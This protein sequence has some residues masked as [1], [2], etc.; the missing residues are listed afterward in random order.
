MRP[1]HAIPPQTKKGPLVHSFHQA[2]QLLP[3][4]YADL[5]DANE[6]KAQ[7]IGL[8]SLQIIRAFQQNNGLAVTNQVD[9][10][11]ARR[12]NE[13]LYEGNV[14]RRILGF[15]YDPKGKPKAGAKV[16][17]TYVKAGTTERIDETLTDETGAYLLYYDPKELTEPP[18][19]TLVVQVLDEKSQAILLSTPVENPKSS[20]T[21]DFHLNPTPNPSTPMLL[22]IH[23][24]ISR[25]NGLPAEGL[26]VLAFDQSLSTETPLGQAITTADGRYLIQYDASK[27]PTGKAKPDLLLKIMSPGKPDLVLA[28]S[29]VMYNAGK[30]ATI[31]VVVKEKDIPKTSEFERLLAAIMP[32][33]DGKPLSDLQENTT[34]QDFTYLARKTGWDARMIAMAVLAAKNAAETKLPAEYFYASSRAGLPTDAGALRRVSTQTVEEAWKK[35]AA[36]NIVPAHFGQETGVTLKAF[37]VHRG[38]RLLTTKARN[39]VSTLKEILDVS[40][41]GNAAL[42]EKFANLYFNHNGPPAAFWDKAKTEL[43]LSDNTIKALR[44]DGK[45]GFLTGNHAPLIQYLKKEGQLDSPAALISKGFYKKER[46]LE[47]LQGQNFAVPDSIEGKDAAE[48]R[49]RYAESMTR[50]MKISYPTAVLAEMVLAGEMPLSK[51]TQSGAQKSSKQ[52]KGSEGSDLR[53]QVHEFFSANNAFEIGK[54]PLKRY[55]EAKPDSTPTPE[56][57]AEI[58]RLQRTWQISPDDDTMRVLLEQDLD[59][60][61][62]I[63]Q[64]DEA[65]FVNRMGKQGI[66][67]A[68]ALLTWNQAHSVHSTVLQLTTAVG[69]YLAN[70]KPYVLSGATTV[71]TVPQ[72]TTKVGYP[73]LEQLFGDLDYC[74]CDHC[75][76]ILSPAAYLVDLLTFIDR[77]GEAERGGLKFSNPLDVLLTRRPDIEHLELSCKNTNTVLPYIDL[78]N[79]IL[80]YHV[81]KDTLSGFYG[82]NAGEMD[83]EELLATPEFV[84]DQVYDDAYDKLIDQVYPATLPF[85]EPLESLRLL[86]EQLE[87]PLPEAMEKLRKNDDFDPTGPDYGWNDILLEQLKISPEAFRVLTDSPWKTLPQYFGRFGMTYEAFDIDMC[88]AKTFARTLNIS[89]KE[90]T[91]LLRTTFIN[92]AAAL[93]PLLENL[94]VDP[95]DTDLPRKGLSFADISNYKHGFLSQQDFI[96]KLPIGVNA[97]PYGGNIG[98]WIKNNHDAIMKLILLTP[99]ENAD[100]NCGFGDLELRY[101][102]P[103]AM[104]NRIQEIDY[105]R[106]YRFVRLWKKLGWTIADTDLVLRA[107]FQHNM[108][109]TNTPVQNLD[110]GFKD[111]LPKLALA[112]RVQDAFKLKGKSALP[113]LM[114]LWSDIDTFGNNSLY[115]QLFLTPSIRSL[116]PYFQDNGTGVFLPAGADT[117]GEHKIA[118]LAAFNLTE[119]DFQSILSY[120]TVID[121]I[122]TVL[123]EASEITLL[124]VSI[125]YRR[126]LLCKSLKIK[127]NELKDL[128]EMAGL[129]PFAK[130]NYINYSNNI[131]LEYRQPDLLQFIEW[132]TELKASGIKLAELRYLLR[133]E[134]PEGKIAPKAD[135]VLNLVKT[136]RIGLQRIEAENTPKDDPK[137]EA[138]AAAMA[139]VF[140][141]ADVDQFFGLLNGTTRFET[142]YP[143]LL[144][145]AEP[146]TQTQAAATAGSANNLKLGHDRLAKALTFNAVMTVAERDNLIQINQNGANSVKFSAAINRLYQQ[147][148][149]LFQKYT[150]WKNWYIA[151]HATPLD[152]LEIRFKALLMQV[153]P[154]LKSRLKKQFIRQTLAEIYGAE[155]ALLDVLLDDKTLVT[156]FSDSQRSAITDFLLPEVNGSSNITV[157]PT[158]PTSPLTGWLEVPTLD[159]WKFYMDTDGAVKH[160][161]F[162]IDGETIT[163]DGSD[164]HFNN[165]LTPIALSPGRIYQFELQLQNAAK[166]DLINLPNSPNHPVVVLTWES[167]GQ[168]KELVPDRF[169]YTAA[170]VAYLQNAFLRLFKIVRLT[171]QLGLTAPEIAFFG[172]D[173]PTIGNKLWNAILG[174]GAMAPADQKTMLGN[175]LN[176]SR[177]KTL[178]GDLKIKDESLIAVLEAP[179]VTVSNELLFRLTGWDKLNLDRLLV[180]HFGKTYADLKDMETFFRVRRV[181][182]LV[183]KAGVSADQ[184][185]TWTGNQPN[186]NTVRNAKQI[187]RAQYD[188]ADWRNVVKPHHDRLRQLRRDALVDYVIYRQMLPIPATAH[189]NTPEKLYEYFLIDVEMEPCME[190]SRIRQAISTVQL[191]V[192]RCLMNL[193]QAE[194]QVV[195]PAAIKANQWEWMKRYRVWEANRKIF[196]W[197]EN[198]LDPELRDNKTPFFADLESELLQADVTADL[199]EQAYLHYL[200]KL[201]DIAKLEICATYLE[202]NDTNVANPTAD[203]ILHVFGR[204]AGLNRKYYYRR[205]EYGYW[206]PWEKVDADIEDNPI[207][208]VIWKGRLVLFWMTVIKKGQDAKPFNAG[209]VSDPKGPKDITNSD[210]N[211]LQ[212]INIEVNLCWSEYY[213]GKWQAKRTSDFRNALVFEGILPNEKLNPEMWFAADNTELHIG[214]DLSMDSLYGRYILS[215]LNSVPLQDYEYVPREHEDRYRNV[216]NSTILNAYYWFG[217]DNEGAALDHDILGNSSGANL[218]QPNKFHLANELET[219]FFLQDKRHVMHIFPDYEEWTLQNWEYIGDVTDTTTTDVTVDDVI[220]GTSFGGGISLPNIEVLDSIDKLDSG[221]EQQPWTGLPG[222]FGAIHIANGW[223]IGANGG[224][225]TQQTAQGNAG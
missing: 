81:A 13:L 135:L 220:Y 3:G 205:F 188:E 169:L 75:R 210:L 16:V 107:L 78:V 55:L 72:P 21:V 152:P 140:D 192:F 172:K 134:D 29:A 183:H 106:F 5:L 33:L 217:L 126:T 148:N 104:H 222:N 99:V 142:V 71:E 88:N 117:L 219:P 54:Q 35:A 163:L 208:P 127:P 24:L 97:T 185:L 164:G 14:F 112:L 46:W 146:L 203:D 95:T 141:K 18:G 1:F 47:V 174:T 124:N 173:W 45:L 170:S 132:N 130:L 79:E 27:L 149:A 186:S 90:L 191:F 36:A 211:A 120:Y 20:E 128:R 195:S 74:E 62:A 105:R 101:A 25:D 190:T 66:G 111:F 57:S 144:L 177:Y 10:A 67:E 100:I 143:D 94:A 198:W 123:T 114:A 9:E 184:L 133:G 8:T 52:A 4:E 122:D 38:A 64:T 125:L 225:D 70:P 224:Q 199:A 76:S 2:L 189:I 7:Q 61:Y 196:L 136:L 154:E 65:S 39:G 121:T 187:L 179:Q 180:S 223:T 91:E 156:A 93:L 165:V 115:R 96:D 32:F 19:M 63:M 197:P 206:T 159:I 92:P 58:A 22:K 157:P 30:D 168:G 59:S 202:E 200:G 41:A 147:S 166:Q 221:S 98:I 145:P 17:A 162:K 176:L 26:Q 84:E 108:V 28:R 153:L 116:D 34:R 53:T 218:V 216:K 110:A 68:A 40:M 215:N 109:V 175:I 31:N 178:K 12:F 6:V 151:F 138:T 194:L 73:T 87:I 171:E 161:I 209:T 193:E 182:D 113:R 83:T 167:T 201:D 11:T 150:D 89:Y 56:V 181:F 204:T 137:G 48:K 158:T 15:C 43:G 77:A 160:A 207:L 69:T 129:N 44:L 85:N 119:A 50:Q 103:D 37:E 86:M 42:Q 139:L 51:T 23:G 60:A 214:F 82:H 155:A 213:N 212:K 102:L 118:L 131:T 49:E 80:E